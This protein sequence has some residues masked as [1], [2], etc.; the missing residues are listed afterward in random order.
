MDRGQA[1][2]K[3]NLWQTARKTQRGEQNRGHFVARRTKKAK[4]GT[5]KGAN[6]GQLPENAPL[7]QKAPYFVLRE[8]FLR[9]LRTKQAIFVLKGYFLRLLRT[10]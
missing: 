10:K 7:E 4:S 3:A 8:Y 2:N 1:Q 9:P 6:R 5:N